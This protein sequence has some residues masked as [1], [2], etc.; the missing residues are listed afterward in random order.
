MGRRSSPP[1]RC[2]TFS[3]EREWESRGA[4]FGGQIDMRAGIHLGDARAIRRSGRWPSVVGAFLLVT[5]MYHGWILTRQAAGSRDAERRIA[6]LEETVREEAPLTEA[7]RVRLE[8]QVFPWLASVL[9]ARVPEAP[10]AS[11]MVALIGESIPE[12]IR[13]Q[14][15]SLESSGR[16]HTLNLTAVSRDSGAIAGWQLVLEREAS[17][18]RTEL[19]E[20]RV[21]ADGARAVRL[22][23]QLHPRPF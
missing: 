6:T 12:G 3:A 4:Y 20:E 23:V 10:L 9:G 19:L 14:R 11:A 2:P 8:T 5:T 15:L 7:E 18:D 1:R 17:I 21:E 16:V 22:R 13:L